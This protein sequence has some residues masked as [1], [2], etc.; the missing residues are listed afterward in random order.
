MLS[1]ATKAKAEED[2]LDAVIKQI[3]QDPAGESAVENDLK[4]KRPASI[5]KKPTHFQSGKSTVKNASSISRP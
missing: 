5:K 1:I 3:N 2:N 4:K